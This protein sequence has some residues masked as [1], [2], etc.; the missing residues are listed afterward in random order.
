[1][2]CPF[3]L[4]SSLEYLGSLFWSLNHNWYIS[5]P[6]NS[7]LFHYYEH[8]LVTISLVKWYYTY[9]RAFSSLLLWSKMAVVPQIALHISCLTRAYCGH[10]RP[11]KDI[12]CI[13]CTSITLFPNQK[14]LETSRNRVQTWSWHN[15]RKWCFFVTHTF[16]V[17]QLTS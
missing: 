5:L 1:M 7:W 16:C 10:F 14:V 13:R 12:F 2:R 9:L 15:V 6:S 3:V 17:C 8:H 4:V 11:S